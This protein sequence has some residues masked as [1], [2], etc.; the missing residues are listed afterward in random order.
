MDSSKFS[1]SHHSSVIQ[2]TVTQTV[3]LL[4]CIHGM[5]CTSLD[6]D[7]DYDQFFMVFLSYPGKMGQNSEL[8]NDSFLAYPFQFINHCHEFIRSYSPFLFSKMVDTVDKCTA[9]NKQIYI[10]NS[11]LYES[12]CHSGL[13]G[14]KE[15]KCHSES[16]NPCLLAKAR[17]Q[18]ICFSSS[19]FSTFGSPHSLL[20]PVLV[21]KRAYC[22]S[23]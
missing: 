13:D 18:L 7:T 17:I 22:L 19:S 12:Q 4:F 2:S 9:E 14:E 10:F 20:L 11:R 6:R 5:S 23:F 16:L 1:A 3:M 8:G 21:N 15:N